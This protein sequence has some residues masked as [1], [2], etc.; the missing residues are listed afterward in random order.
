MEI[1]ELVNKRYSAKKFDPTKK[2]TEDELSKIEDILRVS[3][4][5]INIQPWHF[6]IVTSEEGKKKIAKSTED[7]KNLF[8]RQKILDASAVI[9]FSYKT[10]VDE[11][12][13]KH[14]ID[15]EDKD[16]RFKDEE[17]KNNAL[18]MYM[19]TTLTHRDVLKDYKFWF[20]KQVCISAGYFSL[21]AE[22]IGINTIIIGGFDPSIVNRE[23]SLNQ[24]GFTSSLLV[25]IGYGAEDDYNKYLPKSRLPKSE[26]IDRV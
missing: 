13:V 18:N 25:C 14:V 22:V 4:S 10:D 19:D 5:S 24:K 16:G 9:I 21:A 20:E 26:I 12:Y 2:L 17:F 8:N 11:E 3:P 1:L 23:F 15:C 6:T 7:E